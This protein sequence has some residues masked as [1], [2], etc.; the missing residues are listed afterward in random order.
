M[1]QNPAEKPYAAEI[2]DSLSIS[3]RPSGSIP[4]PQM[5]EQIDEGPVIQSAGRELGVHDVTRQ[6]LTWDWKQVLS[7]QAGPL[8]RKIGTKNSFVIL[9]IGGN[10]LGDL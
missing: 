1:T 8:A 4:A 3:L 5:G 6:T 7:H 2:P 10:A 9:C